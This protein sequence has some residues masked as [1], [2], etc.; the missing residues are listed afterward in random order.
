[1]RLKIEFPVLKGPRGEMISKQQIVDE[2][3]DLCEDCQKWLF[4][5]ASKRKEELQ[6]KEQAPKL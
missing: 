1:M 6:K 2:I 3:W 5:L 4:D